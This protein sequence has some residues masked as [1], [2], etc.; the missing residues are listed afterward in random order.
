LGFS[1]SING[2]GEY[3]KVLGAEIGSGGL[4]SKG[5]SSGRHEKLWRYVG[6]ALN[7]L[8]ELGLVHFCIRMW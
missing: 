6:L 4:D 8:G 3:L 1:V 7:D 2:E 5:R